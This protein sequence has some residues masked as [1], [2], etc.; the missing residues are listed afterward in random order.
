MLLS[1]L[2]TFK[3]KFEELNRCFPKQKEEDAMEEDT[4]LGIRDVAER[5]PIKT[6]TQSSENPSD[7]LKGVSTINEINNRWSLS[8]QEFGQRI[9]NSSIWSSELQP[10]G[11]TSIP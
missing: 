5:R 6:L 3:V 11:A 9:Q 1:I 2:D 7:P 4:E 10:P 8:L